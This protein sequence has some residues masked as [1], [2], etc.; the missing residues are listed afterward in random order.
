MNDD[1]RN[2]AILI[3]IGIVVGLVMLFILLYLAGLLWFA[4]EVAVNTAWLVILAVVFL[5]I[6][7]MIFLGPYYF[8]KPH[9]VHTHGDYR[10]EDQKE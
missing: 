4:A 7:L 10:L 2:T 6:L 3:P 8:F 9:T 5:S 1:D